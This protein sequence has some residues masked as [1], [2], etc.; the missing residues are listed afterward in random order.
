MNEG[1]CPI[2]V[3]EGFYDPKGFGLTD[4]PLV[5]FPFQGLLMGH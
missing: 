5:R 4:K 3:T 1:V 2:E